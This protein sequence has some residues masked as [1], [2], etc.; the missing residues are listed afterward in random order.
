MKKRINLGCGGTYM[1]GWVNCDVNHRVKADV[2]FDANKPPYPLESDMAEFILMDNVME[3]L[4]DIPAVMDELYRILAPGGVLRVLVPYGKTEGALWDP[5][6]THTFT[7]QSMDYFCFNTEKSKITYSTHR[8]ELL[9]AKLLS[10]NNNT[11]SK[12]RNLIPFR[13]YLKYFL[14]NMYDGI[15]FE[16]RKPA[17]GTSVANAK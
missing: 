6:H 14:W 7:E 11:H 2:Y 15:E 17:T 8:F 4:D 3:H 12:I 10:F 5:T 16:L 9:K 13:K 1:D